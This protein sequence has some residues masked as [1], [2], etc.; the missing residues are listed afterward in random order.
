MTGRI[1]SSSSVSPEF[2]SA[3]TTSRSMIMPMSP[4][5]ASPGCRK[6]DGLPVLASVA[7]ILLPTCP[8]L[9][10]PV[11]TMRPSQASSSRQASAKSSPRRCSSA[12]TAWDSVASTRRPRAIRESE[13]VHAGAGVCGCGFTRPGS[14]VAALTPAVRIR[15]V[16]V[17]ATASR[18]PAQPA[19]GP[20]TLR[21]PG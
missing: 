4:C 8:D 9:P 16:P 12:A 20:T 19:A 6:N 5:T 7:A 1:V 14:G 2:E 17:P 18:R 11:T 15:G 21:R 3:S 10:M 13:A